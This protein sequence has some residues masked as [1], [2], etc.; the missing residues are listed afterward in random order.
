MTDLSS[1]KS[2]FGPASKH[3]LK[4]NAECVAKQ[5][6]LGA[7]NPVLQITL[8][9][10]DGQHGDLAPYRIMEARVLTFSVGKIFQPRNRSAGSD[11]HNMVAVHE[12]PPTEEETKLPRLE[13]DPPPEEMP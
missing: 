13:E 1:S 2:W 4:L 3:F 6:E 7:F 10:D 12:T 8:I 5:S 9:P 11:D